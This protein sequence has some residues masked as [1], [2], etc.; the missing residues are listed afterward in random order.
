MRNLRHALATSVALL[1]MLAPLP[2]RAAEP[3]FN[4]LLQLQQSGRIT[5]QVANVCGP[6]V[7]G[8]LAYLEGS[9]F[10]AITGPSG[11]FSLEYVP[12]GTYTL[13]VE[14]PGGTSVHSTPGVQVTARQITDVGTIQVPD[15]QSD[16]AN[17][18]ACGAVC[19]NANATAACVHGA[20]QLTCH[21][22]FA[23]CDS[24]NANGCETNLAS[25]VKN[26]G[27]C[28]QVCSFANAAAV[29]T[30]G[31]C[32]VGFCNKPFADCDG[33][34]ANG[35]EVNLAVDVN[36]CGACGNRCSPNTA[37]VGGTCTVALTCAPGTANCDGLATNGCE[38][39]ITAD[40]NNCGA[41]GI[42][43][44][45]PNAATNACTGGTC[46]I[47]ACAPGFADCDRLAANGCE[48]NVAN[49]VNNCGA[50]GNRCG[51]LQICSNG[52]CRF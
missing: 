6:E 10:T 39:N 40:V 21:A 46:T 17:C 42:R 9:S 1:S 37:C 33:V 30:N 8:S 31:V 36:N 7:T 12:Q 38:T 20:C 41:C 19:G 35:C 29:C 26:C 28:G 2:A 22:G 24:G 11:T 13:D 34:A 3:T 32:G 50:C 16:V 44:S 52:V 27:A 15:V 47:A 14:I 45:F 49:D 23:N 4:P 5:G 25:D 48:T 51:F 18:G 43:C